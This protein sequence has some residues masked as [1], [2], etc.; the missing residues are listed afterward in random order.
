MTITD[1]ELRREIDILLKRRQ[2]FW[3]T[4]RNIAILLG[5]VAALVGAAAGVTG[6]QLGSRPPQQIIVH[7]DGGLK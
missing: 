1:E 3:E 7:M 6:F 4:P 2:A 5:V